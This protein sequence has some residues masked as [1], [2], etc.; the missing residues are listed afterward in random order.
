MKKTKEIILISVLVIS[1][2]AVTIIVAMV[3]LLKPK[4]DDGL[5]KTIKE[6]NELNKSFKEDNL[7]KENSYDFNE[8]Y[9][10]MEYI[11]DNT[12]EII[13]KIETIYVNP[14][15]EYGN[16]NIVTSNEEGKIK[17][18]LYVCLEKKCKIKEIEKYEV[19]MKEE[20]RKVV[21]I[22][23][24]EQVMVKVDNEWKFDSPVILC[25]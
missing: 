7:L 4:I 15:R 6:I 3:V 12:G 5:T 14:F 20:T 17:E 13:K 10:C 23:N 18:K 19:A 16:F 11:G 2:V 9:T 1:I 24:Q 8:N 25:E 22:A 21:R